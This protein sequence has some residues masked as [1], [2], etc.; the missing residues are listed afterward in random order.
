MNNSD[1]NNPR[2]LIRKIEIAGYKKIKIKQEKIYDALVIG[3]TAPLPI[4]YAR[5]DTRFAQRIREGMKEEIN[6]LIDTYGR[7]VPSMSAIG[8]NEHAYVR[9]QLTWFKK[10][11]GIHW[12]DVTDL[13]HQNRV[14]TLVD[15]WYTTRSYV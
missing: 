13:K 15:A 11:K 6:R 2:R 10:Q 14:A 9:R 12:F 1:W 7:D 5:I 4:L 8:L 3:L